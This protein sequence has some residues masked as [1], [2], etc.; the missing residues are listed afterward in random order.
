MNCTITFSIKDEDGADVIKQMINVLP[1]DSK[2]LD[3]TI[4]GWTILDGLLASKIENLTKVKD[5]HINVKK[6]LKEL[7]ED[8]IN[9]IDC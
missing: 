8:K 2:H 1:D 5:L 7:A 6:E 3:I 4:N 9:K